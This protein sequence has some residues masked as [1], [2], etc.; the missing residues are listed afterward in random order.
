[1]LSSMHILSLKQGKLYGE[2]IPI[3][4]LPQ[5]FKLPQRLILLFSLIGSWRERTKKG[6]TEA[7]PEVAEPQQAASVG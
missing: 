5:E 1:M 7:G 3:E 6:P 4:T 2:R